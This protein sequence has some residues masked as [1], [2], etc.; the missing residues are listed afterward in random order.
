MYSFLLDLHKQV[1]LNLFHAL[2]FCFLSSLL[3]HSDIIYLHMLDLVVLERKAE[4]HHK[5]QVDAEQDNKYVE[6]A[7]Q[8]PNCKVKDKSLPFISVHSQI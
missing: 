3:L 2:S 7:C 8:A 6:P 4:Y 1:H 5:P